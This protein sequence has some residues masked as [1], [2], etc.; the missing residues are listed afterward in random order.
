MFLCLLLRYYVFLPRA[1][2]LACVCIGKVYRVREKRY[3]NCYFVSKWYRESETFFFENTREMYVRHRSDDQSL[4]IDVSAGNTTDL[5]MIA[6]KSIVL[7]L[8]PLRKC[9]ID[10]MK[11]CTCYCVWMCLKKLLF[12]LDG[13]LRNSRQVRANGKHEKISVHTLL[14]LRFFSTLT[15]NFAELLP[16]IT[17][18]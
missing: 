1:Y 3:K 12:F 16:F 13:E 10:N 11:I 6:V 17:A 8:F 2:N 4:T 7:D 5:C 9:S 18:D 15:F 14:F